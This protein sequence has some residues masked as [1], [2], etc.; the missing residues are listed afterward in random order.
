MGEGLSIPRNW[1][2]A[3]L[4]DVCDILDSM[5]IPVNAT[6][7]A[8]RLEG[9]RSADLYPY[10]G[11]TGQVGAIDGYLFDGECVLIGEYGAPFLEP[12]RDTAYTVN[13]RFWVNNHAHI[14]KSCFSNKYL[15]FY[16]NQEIGK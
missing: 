8:K 12:F 3:P 9:K 2:L 4:E 10:Y 16:L 13:G 6:K 14:L 11:A 5:R 15:C 7:R 1:T